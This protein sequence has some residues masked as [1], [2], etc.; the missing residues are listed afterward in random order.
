M[1]VIAL[2]AGVLLVLVLSAL[3]YILLLTVNNIIWGY[4]G[5]PISKDSPEYRK[6]KKLLKIISI[7]LSLLILITIGLLNA[8]GR[9]IEL[10]VHI[11][12]IPESLKRVPVEQA[13][14]R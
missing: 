6:R 11:T 2:F 10:S 7:P 5:I 12:V 9:L 4:K 1:G 14:R 13:T 3:S 8:G